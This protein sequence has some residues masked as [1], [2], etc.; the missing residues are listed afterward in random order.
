[1]GRVGTINVNSTLDGMEHVFG[2]W[3][4]KNVDVWGRVWSGCMLLGL[5]NHGRVMGYQDWMV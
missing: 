3:L 5:M 2:N 1:M 4:Y